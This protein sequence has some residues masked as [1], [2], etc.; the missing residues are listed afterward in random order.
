[1]LS[2]IS[3]NRTPL[4]D[5]LTAA[6]QARI[7]FRATTPLGL[8]EDEVTLFW[9]LLIQ[10]LTLQAQ[11][12]LRLRPETEQEWATRLWQPDLEAVVDRADLADTRLVRLV[13]RLL[14]LMQLAA[15]AG[16]PLSALVERLEQGWG[17]P[18]AELPLSSERI[19]SLLQRWRGWC[20]ERGLLTYSLIAELYG[21]WLLP[22]PTY[23]SGLAQRYG[24]VLADDLD[25]YPAIIRPFLESLLD[26]GATAVFSFNPDGAVRQGMGA[27]PAYLQSL[28]DR[29]D[30]QII[31]D[32]P[33]QSLYP[34]VGLP[35]LELLENPIYFASL[36]QSI[37][38]LQTTTRAQLIRQ[39]AE[40]IIQAVQT[41][42]VEPRDIAIIGPGLDPIARYALSTI[43]SGRGIPVTLLNDQRP[44]VSHA[45]IRGLLA[46]LSCVYPG[47]GHH[48]QREQVAEMLVV[49]TQ[50]QSSLGIDP[51]R[52]GLLAD[53]CFAPHPDAPQLLPLT[54]FARWDRLGF[55]VA[56]A[57]RDV[58]QWLTQQRQQWQ[59]RLIAN[60]VVFLDRAIQK[61][62]LGGA[63]LP[64]EQLATL[65][66]LIET[67]QHYWEVEARLQKLEPGEGTSSLT[68]QHFIE[69]L[70]SGAVTANPFPV[71]SLGMTSNAVT[72]ATVFQYRSTRPVHR[73]QFW[74]DAGTPRWLSGVDAL[75]GAPLFLQ[76]WDGQAWTLEQTQQWNEQ[77]LRRILMDLLARTT[78][79]VFLCYCDLGTNGQE[80]L[81]ALLSVVNA[82]V[83]WERSPDGLHLMSHGDT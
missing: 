34:E 15:L 60:P 75:F 77:R 83:P 51:V 45:K 21:Q 22:H 24:V 26:R 81:G 13:R 36:P 52:A 70:R 7:P 55:P 11:F 54:A 46:L 5:Q 71:S 27:D 35:I 10:Q 80:Q 33:C 64:S 49:L 61:F 8:F 69:L 17:Q 12:P 9:P 16:L 41:G 14:D 76:D 1:V 2:A 28:G 39:T 59:E 3:D 47:L 38:A 31:L 19:V 74:F 4:V 30:Q 57:Y 48:L 25:E 72:L 58:V 68:V 18:T 53:H 66:A 43:L 42:Q 37:C 6:T 23:Q 20:L 62:F 44:L 67:A 50:G 65:R 73:W 78:Q 63:T 79:R 82:A 56:E 40:T 29:C 32:P